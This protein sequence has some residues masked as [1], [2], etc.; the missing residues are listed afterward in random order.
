M[1]DSLCEFLTQNAMKKI[2]LTVFFTL[3]LILQVDAQYNTGY[4]S[5]NFDAIRKS[6]DD[7]QRQYDNNL[8]YKRSLLN[9]AKD[10]IGKQADVQFNKAINYYIGLLDGILGIN[11]DSE[12]SQMAMI[13]DGI[14]S[15]IRDYNKRAEKLKNPDLYWKKGLEYYNKNDFNNAITQFKTVQSLAPDFVEV[16]AFL[17]YSQFAL[18]DYNSALGNFNRAV[19]TNPNKDIYRLRGWT[20]YYLFDFYGALSDFTQQ[21]TLDPT[22]PLG[23]YNRGLAKTELKDGYG[24][25]TDYKKAIDLDPSFSMAYNNLGWVKFEQKNYPEALKYVNLA[26]EKDPSNYIAL[27]SRAEIKFNMGDFKGCISDCN[28]ALSMNDKLANCYFIRGRACYKQGK[29]TEA[30]TDWSDAGQY[31]KQEAYS[32]IEKYCK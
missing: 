9:W 7:Q 20:K 16:Y 15:E 14:K 25:V 8:A 13:E 29:K 4:V 18:R 19:E 1:E 26:I 3:S 6:V 12:A 28:L 31:G 17:G 10:L 11:L 24:A 32:F 22:N 2:Y 30:C 23:Y 27:D 21:I 5:P